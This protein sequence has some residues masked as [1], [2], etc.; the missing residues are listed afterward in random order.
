MDLRRQLSETSVVVADC[1]D[2][3]NMVSA[4]VLHFY[5]FNW[6]KRLFINTGI[7]ILASALE[8][9]LELA[10]ILHT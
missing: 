5:A 9:A 7:G 2:H 3:R 10:S 1:F 8:L 6:L 4:I